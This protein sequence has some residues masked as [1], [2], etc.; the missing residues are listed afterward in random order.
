M[1]ISE[2]AKIIQSKTESKIRRK[3]FQ[4]EEYVLYENDYPSF[5]CRSGDNPAAG[6]TMEWWP[7]V[8]D[9]AA[10]DWEIID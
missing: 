2:L 5:Y 7:S 9:L 8:E 6:H 10:D 4:S 1:N 3:S